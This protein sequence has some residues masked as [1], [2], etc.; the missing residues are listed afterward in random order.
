MVTVFDTV[1]F[2]IIILFHVHESPRS[3][4]APLPADSPLG[5][6]EYLCDRVVLELLVL[7]AFAEHVTPSGLVV[8]HQSDGG[9]EPVSEQTVQPLCPRC[10]PDIFLT[11]A[12]PLRGSSLTPRADVAVGHAAHTQ[13]EIALQLN[14]R[15]VS[16]AKN[17]ESGLQAERLYQTW[18]GPFSASGGYHKVRGGW[19]RWR[20]GGSALPRHLLQDVG[21]EAFPNNHWCSLIIRFGVR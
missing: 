18:F 19:R 3:K 21:Q 5:H 16:M 10:L 12:P 15:K 2:Y 14:D 11:Y 7:G 4:S 6:H 20:S 1:I 13:W 8:C 9:L 17:A